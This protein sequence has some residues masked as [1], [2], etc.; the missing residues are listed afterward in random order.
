M[1]S[2]RVEAILFLARQLAA[3]AEGMTLDEMCAATDENRRTVERWRDALLRLFPQM[4]EIP[5]GRS[6]RFRI[7]GGLDSFFQSPTR[8][9]LLELEKVVKNLRKSGAGARADTLDSLDKKIRA[10]MKRPVVRRIEPD[11]EVLLQAEMIAIQPGPRPIESPD[12]LLTIRDAMLRERMLGFV[13]HGGSRP[14]NSREVVPYGLLFGRMNYLIAAD[15]G[16]THPKTWRMDKCENICV[17][18]KTGARPADFNLAAYANASFGY[19]QGEMH[20]VVIHIRPSGMEE[21]RNWRFHSTQTVE[22]LPTGGALVRFRATGMRELAWHLFTWG[23]MVEV[24]EP[25]ELR[26]TLITELRAALAN[27]EEQSTYRNSSS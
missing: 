24:I 22:E 5:D 12:V 11:L 10:A 14:G 3:S 9:E 6:K 25:A 23:T 27:H 4:E 18:D 2:E 17:Q 8:E 15:A 13:Y 16:T 7:A 20:D 26:E 21:L 1:R 19:F